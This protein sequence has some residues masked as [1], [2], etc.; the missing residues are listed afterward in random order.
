MGTIS[1][2]FLENI[3]REMLLKYKPPYRILENLWNFGVINFRNFR[4][5]GVVLRNILKISKKF[6]KEFQKI[7][8]KY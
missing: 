2:K 1:R 8:E 3:P 6:E 4:K 5:S 7:S